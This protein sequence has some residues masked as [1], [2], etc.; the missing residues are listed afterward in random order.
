M[1]GGFK[2]KKG[3]KFPGR[4][5]SYAP[6]A[7]QKQIS[8]QDQESVERPSF[9]VE[10][11]LGDPNIVAVKARHEKFE[12]MMRPRNPS[13]ENNLDLLKYDFQPSSQKI[14]SPLKSAL[15]KKYSEVM[16][17]IKLTSEQRISKL[18]T[19]F[20]VIFSKL[21]IS[22]AQHPKYCDKYLELMIK[23]KNWKAVTVG[24]AM[25]WSMSGNQ[26]PLECPDPPE[27]PF[28]CK[29]PDCCLTYPNEKYLCRVCFLKFPTLA[30]LYVHEYETHGRLTQTEFSC[31]VCYASFP[32]NP[33]SLRAHFYSQ[34][35]CTPEHEECTFGCKTL[36]PKRSSKS[37]A[38]H[39][40]SE[41]VCG[42]CN[43]LL[44]CLLQEHMVAFHDQNYSLRAPQTPLIPLEPSTNQAKEMRPAGKCGCK[45]VC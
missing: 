18:I 12:K 5:P 13:P 1:Y 8:R 22:K 3:V 25:I 19:E 32:K 20:R 41:H 37:L 42:I 44:S 6:K 34:H 24:K 28:V 23:D 21:K 30:D 45:H 7:S 11:P 15:D 43:D 40:F 2:P 9:K 29:E 39:V 35:L 4:K 36:I 33:L 16:K 26:Q 10:P 38:D 14:D 27:S 31:D 17:E